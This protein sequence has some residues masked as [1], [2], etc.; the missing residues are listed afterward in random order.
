MITDNQIEELNQRL[1]M[2]IKETCNTIG[3]DK[4][5]LKW[6]EGALEKCSAT[7]L[8]GKIFDLLINQ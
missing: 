1:S 6:N 8:Q 2:V 7:E 4:C 5:G 3:C